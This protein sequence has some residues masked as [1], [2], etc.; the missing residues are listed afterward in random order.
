MLLNAAFFNPAVNR[1]LSF[2]QVVY[3]GGRHTF[4][5]IKSAE[6]IQQGSHL[7]F[8]AE[9]TIAI[10]IHV[11]VFDSEPDVTTTV[12]NDFRS[13]WEADFKADNCF[14]DNP[15]RVEF[16]SQAFGVGEPHGKI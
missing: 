7:T 14:N 3:Q 11:I 10:G 6:V 5:F 8:L 12:E 2:V 4:I 13:N 1:I 16:W 15:E 9:T